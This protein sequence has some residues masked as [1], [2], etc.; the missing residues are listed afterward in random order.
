METIT[1]YAFYLGAVLLFSQAV[2]NLTYS[3]NR[4]LAKQ[5]RIRDIGIRQAMRRNWICPATFGMTLVLGARETPDYWS[6]TIVGSV[7]VA[8][9]L[10]LCVWTRS[11]PTEWESNIG[12][13]IPEKLR[14]TV[15]GKKLSS[16]FFFAAGIAW[17]RDVVPNVI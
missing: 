9:A 12:E 4:E 17:I 15:R 11:R 5:T 10:T 6:W 1:F 2:F 13:P 8:I 3:M 14:K 7:L 16:I